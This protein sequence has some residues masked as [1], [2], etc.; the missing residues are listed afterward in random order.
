MTI[1]RIRRNELWAC[2]IETTD[3]TVRLM[4]PPE[5]ISE[6][7]VALCTGSITNWEWREILKLWRARVTA[8]DPRS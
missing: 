8:S 3:G 4:P 7:C 6:G 2:L 5:F 1:I